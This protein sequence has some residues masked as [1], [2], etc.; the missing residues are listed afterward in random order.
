[1][2]PVRRERRAA[3]LQRTGLPIAKQKATLLV[4]AMRCRCLGTNCGDYG[5]RHQNRC[6]AALRRAA[7]AG[8]CA[9]G[10]GLTGF[11]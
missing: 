3:N 8:H 11:W 9:T 6:H 2:I 1:M 10:F 4:V 7:Q 5:M